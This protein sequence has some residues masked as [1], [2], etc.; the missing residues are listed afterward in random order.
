M[1]DEELMIRVRDDDDRDAFNKLSVRWAAPLFRFFRRRRGLQA[2]DAAVC[3]NVTLHN[4]WKGR[5]SYNAAFPFRV[6]IHGIANNVAK[7]FRTRPGRRGLIRGQARWLFWVALGPEDELDRHEISDILR[8]TFA[9]NGYPLPDDARVEVV[10]REWEW[11]ITWWVKSQG[12]AEYEKKGYR[13]KRT[14][15]L[16]VYSLG[17]GM[18]LVAVAEEGNRTSQDDSA[19]LAQAELLIRLLHARSEE[20]KCVLRYRYWPEDGCDEEFVE[21]YQHLLGAPTPLNPTPRFAEWVVDGFNNPRGT[22]TSH[23][24][25]RE[26]TGVGNVTV[27]EVCKCFALEYGLSA[28]SQKS[29]VRQL[30]SIYVEHFPKTTKK[31]VLIH[32]WY[33]LAAGNGDPTR[34]AIDAVFDG[35]QSPGDAELPYYVWRSQ[36][37]PSSFANDV[38]IDP[39]EKP[40]LTAW[41]N[42][43]RHRVLRTL[44][45]SI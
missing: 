10:T 9:A 36:E 14:Q 23:L 28:Y 43:Y 35:K 19:N 37:V 27:S 26:H 20:H 33:S 32:R 8:D 38:E 4:A 44:L 41:W 18:G 39:N 1:T 11:T 13:V 17:V 22:T 24:H 3:V 34:N 31:R 30:I 6:W 42:Q 40:Q 25:C 15:R 16:D 5:K 45:A 2:A 12:A 29:M 21:E 7:D